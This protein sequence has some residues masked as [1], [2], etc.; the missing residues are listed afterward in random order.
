MFIMMYI[1]DS[2]IVTAT[3]WDTESGPERV[4]TTVIRA[5]FSGH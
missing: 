3:Y 2:V 4:R 5:S 1:I